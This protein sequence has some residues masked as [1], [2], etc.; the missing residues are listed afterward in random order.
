MK[1]TIRTYLRRRAIWSMSAAFGGWL[2]IAASIF[3]GN[4]T[5]DGKPEIPLTAMGAVLFI[6]GAVS[7]MFIRCPKCAYKFGQTV[8]GLVFS[9]GGESQR[10]NFCPHCGIALDKL[11]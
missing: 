2:V 6:G 7:L 11:L 3:S 9:W 10:V 4:L 8:A 5:N 1:E